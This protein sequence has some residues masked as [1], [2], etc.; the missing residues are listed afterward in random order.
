MRLIEQFADAAPHP[1][2][3]ASIRR[4]VASLEK[5]APNYEEMDAAQAAEV[6]QQAPQILGLIKVLGALKSVEYEH[7]NEDGADVYLV[8]FEHGQVQ[9]T[10]GALTADGK[11]QKRQFQLL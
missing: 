11:V 8:R 1:E 6:R 5:G 4:Y 10:I 2:R 3:E 7:G 9:W